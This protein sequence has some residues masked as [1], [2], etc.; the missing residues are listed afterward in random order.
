MNR[1]LF[2]EYTGFGGGSSVSL[3]VLVDGLDRTCY[4]PVFLF[5]DKG[6]RGHWEGEEVYEYNGSSLDNFDFASPVNSIIWWYRFALF[7]CLGVKEL[8]V[9]PFMLR[10]IKP[11]IVHINSGPSVVLGVVC[12]CMR[13]PVVWHI[14][15]LVRMNG[16]GWLQDWIYA[17]C[18]N[19][20]IA[21]SNAV[22]KRLP[23]TDQLGKISV[24]YNAVTV[25]EELHPK[26]VTLRESWGGGRTD[27]MV[28]LLGTVNF[29]KGYGFL[30]KV[31]EETREFSEIKYVLAGSVGDSPAGAVREFLRLVYRRSKGGSG[32]LRLEREKILLLWE[33]I[34]DAGR[35][36]FSGRVNAAEALRAADVVVCPNQCTEPFGRT[37]VEAY[38]Q[39]TPVLAMKVNAFDETVKNGVTGY[40]LDNDAG[41]WADQLIELFQNPKSVARLGERARAESFHYNASEHVRII[42]DIYAVILGNKYK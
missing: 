42:S 7:L 39:G 30:A 41:I 25:P 35:A 2:Y 26:N 3:K 27:F 33:D 24:L 29:D 4:M 37:V 20:V 31:A 36:C 6:N 38:A 23:R 13:I 11:D 17:A 28:L 9:L 8:F 40:L 12:R 14:R 15:E 34:L 22:R 21:V 18:S 32:K 1:I 10:R 19:Q 16:L 5:G